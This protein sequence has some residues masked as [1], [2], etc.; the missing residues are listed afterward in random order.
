VLRRAALASAL[1]ASSLV[2]ASLAAA[3]QDTGGTR[4][5]VSEDEATYAAYVQPVLEARCATLDCHGN[6]ERPLRLYAA[7]GLRATDALR[8]R[9]LAAEEL[10][11]NVRS[12]AAVDPGAAPEAS[13]V[14]SK[15]LVGGQAH[16][17]GDLWTS[18]D[19]PQVVCVRSWL[20]G[21][22]DVAACTTAAAQPDVK[23]RDP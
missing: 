7:T 13:L 18:P 8:D 6:V 21:A 14:L 4:P 22:V 11:A 19:E 1:L 2:A 5:L 12:L 15:P 3:C 10:T 9:P 23:L 20:A 16:E 17:G